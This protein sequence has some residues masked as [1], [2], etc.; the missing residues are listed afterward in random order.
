MT[1]QVMQPVNL[2]LNIKMAPDDYKKGTFAAKSYQGHKQ[3]Q[4]GVS[5]VHPRAAH[6]E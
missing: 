2:P 3:E 4:Y 5:L 6:N 1:S